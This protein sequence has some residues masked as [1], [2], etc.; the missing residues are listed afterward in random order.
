MDEH[1]RKTI[2]TYDVIA[3]HY[4]ITA[5]PE[6]RAWE[7]SSMRLFASYLPGSRVLVPGCGDGRD[8][9]YLSSLGLDVLSFDLSDGML[10]EAR[11]LD[12][13]GRYVKLDLREVASLGQTFD[14]V[15]AS[16]CL[17]HLRRGEFETFVNDIY[18]MLG[19]GGVFYLNLKIGTGEEYRAVPGDWYPGGEQARYRLQGDRYYVYYQRQELAQYFRPYQRLHERE[20]QHAE[21]VVELWLRKSAEA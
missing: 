13:R 14:G 9:R 21:E 19:P 6:L 7:E 1:V 2:A 18:A 4:R 15:F 16:G 12:A 8:S 10:E 3:P 20:L 11:K 5:I 17:Y